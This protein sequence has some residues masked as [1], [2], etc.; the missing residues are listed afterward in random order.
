MKTAISLPDELY[1]EVERVRQLHGMSRSHFFAEAARQYTATLDR[2]SLT[3]KINAALAMIESM[4]DAEDD[5]T[6]AVVAYSHRR[7]A[8]RA[9]A[10]DW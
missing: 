6:A 2:G 9:D 4:P 1:E 8:E 3:A 10:E 7:L 5:T